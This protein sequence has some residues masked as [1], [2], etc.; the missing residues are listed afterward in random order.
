[1]PAQMP[2]LDLRQ[3]VVV[4]ALEVVGSTVLSAED[5]TLF[6]QPVLGRRVPLQQVQ[7]VA[8]NITRFYVDRGFTTSRAV[9]V[10]DTVPTGRLRI[11]VIEGRL[12]DIQ[13]SGNRRL[14]TSYLR[15]RLQ[16]VAKPPLNTNALEDQ[17][18]LLRASP[19]IANVEAS[20]RPGEKV[21]ESILVVRI[22]EDPQPL[23]LSF[24]LDNYVPPSIAPQR[25]FVS[26][27]YQN[28]SGRGD[29]IFGSYAVGLNFSDWQRA[30]LN[31]YTLTYRVPLNARDGTLQFRAVVTNNRITERPFAGFNITGESQLYELSFRQPLVRSVRQELALSGAL[32]WQQS[33]IFVLDVVSTTNRTS[34]LQLGVDYLRRDRRGAWLA[35]GRF[36]WGLPILG[37][38][39]IPDGPGDLVTPDGRFFSFQA[40]GQRVLNFGNDLLLLLRADAQIAAK[41]LLPQH[42][43]VIGGAQSVRGYRQ[44]ARAGDNGFRLSVESRI[45]AARD[46]GGR[47]VFQVAP[48]IEFGR[49]WNKR[50]NPNPPLPPQTLAGLGTGLLWSPVPGLDIRFDAALPLVY[51]RDRGRDAQDYGLYFQVNYQAF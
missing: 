43:F 33:Q 15:D 44:N 42:Q 11:E 41:P 8:D 37:A 13:I 29:E 1:M 51:N 34:V 45:P 12:A 26:L 32:A 30:A 22:E 17:L 14:L 39:D 9:I 24:G 23:V 19:F 21:G 20:L 36:N 28:L 7:D 27:G 46:S 4:E 2:P 10:P 35:L 49:V 5:I 40:Q 6:T 38:T 31:E 25:A 47:V 18:R 48:F 50:N 16:L 3:E